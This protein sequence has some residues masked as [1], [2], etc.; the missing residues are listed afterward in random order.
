MQA[1]PPMSPPPHSVLALSRATRELEYARTNLANKTAMY[2]DV[3]AEN[4]ALKMQIQQLNERIEKLEEQKHNLACDLEGARATAI[5]FRD[6]KRP[7]SPGLI[8]KE[9]KEEEEEE[10]EED[11]EADFM[12]EDQAAGNP[13]V[14]EPPASPEEKSQKLA[15]KP[16]AAPM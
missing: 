2:A 6:R 13:Y 14:G 11:P 1:R 8:K 12:A 3:K 16:S 9:E 7:L 5:F 10:A 4:A 15:P